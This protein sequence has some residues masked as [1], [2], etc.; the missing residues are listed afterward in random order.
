MGTGNAWSWLGRFEAAK[1]QRALLW[2]GA[3]FL[4]LI[5]TGDY[6]LI[7]YLKRQALADAVRATRNLAYVLA[8]QTDRS[9]QAVDI[10]TTSIAQYFRTRGVSSAAALEEK[11]VSPEVSTLLREKTAGLQH[12]GTLNLTSARG[13]PL[14][15]SRPRGPYLPDLDLADREHIRRANEEPE[16]SLIITKPFRRS[17]TG[18]WTVV[19]GKPIRTPA[20][21]TIGV[22]SALLQTERIEQLYANLLLGPN[23]AISM[24][25]SDGILLVRY[26]RSEKLIGTSLAGTKAFEQ[27]GATGQNGVIQAQSPIDGS[28]RIIGA[29]AAPNYP[30]ITV[31]AASVD[32]ALS[33]WKKARASLIFGGVFAGL[34]ISCLIGFLAGFSEN[35]AN[36]RA[37]LA[38]AHQRELAEL[39]EREQQ[40]KLIHLATHDPL[41]GLPNRLQF[42]AHLVETLGAMKPGEQAAIHYIDLDRFKSINDSF[43]H[44]AGDDLLVLVATRLRA[45]IRPNHL[46]ARLGGDEFAIVQN[47]EGH[48]EESSRLAR[49]ILREM[50]RPFPFQHGRVTLGASVGIAIAS[51]D[52]DPDDILKKADLALYAAKSR[53]RSRSEFFKPQM[54]EAA[55]E[56]LAIEQEFYPALEAGEFV[57]YFQPQVDL[58]STD[59]VGFEAL[60]RWNHPKKGLLSPSSFIGIAEETGFIGPL[61][62]WVIKEACTTL[63]SWPTC[64][65]IAINVS[66]AQFRNT[67]VP[68]VV[69]QALQISGISPSQLEVEVT[70]SLFISDAEP[71]LPALH[72]IKA[73]GVSI[74]MDDFG[75]GYGSL[76]CL[77]LFPFD[78]LKIDQSFVRELGARADCHAIVEAAT[79]LAG[80]LGIQTTAE[81]I[82]TNRH[83]LEARALGCREG[84]GYFFGAPMSAADAA[85]LTQ[86]KKLTMP[87]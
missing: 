10:A 55:T 11:A 28:E 64:S 9:L 16:A 29:F 13:K 37:A 84:Q 7:D 26:P 67:D 34:V 73:L 45:V 51:N 47:L 81:G 66:A 75:T 61:G 25:R 23:T 69:R 30:V 39:A 2:T 87:A 33:E 58:L 15:S 53:G 42:R 54:L 44:P 8:E 19:L 41:T 14:N 59:V 72:E 35:L 63:A 76:S 20:G 6:L 77:T 4:L 52:C 22:I 48:P 36:A 27:L 80:R 38:V 83:L 18:E 32:D 86:T 50:Q 74:A 46:L 71:A 85:K 82:E 57:L 31:V 5:A 68:S 65:K 78:K 43:G 21:G 17:T 3:A 12:I 60:V 62:A 40:E 79:S 49:R 70:E 1:R 56:R 24:H